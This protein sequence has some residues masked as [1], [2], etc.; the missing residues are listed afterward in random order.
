[1]IAASLAQTPDGARSDR[2]ALGLS[3][4]RLTRLSGVGR[5]KICLFE[6]GGGELTPDEERRI[7]IALQAEALRL[8]SAD[9]ALV[10]AQGA[11]EVGARPT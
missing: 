7:R 1:M 3:Q 10:L 9:D 11:A 4:R 6:S 5:F 8:R 2:E